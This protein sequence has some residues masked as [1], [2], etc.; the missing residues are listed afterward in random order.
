[1]QVP[2]WGVL[3]CN[4]AKLSHSSGVGVG[5]PAWKLLLPQVLEAL[6]Q[7]QEKQECGRFTGLGILACEVYRS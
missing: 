1:M 7:T 6:N 2:C 4:Y 5:A 3:L